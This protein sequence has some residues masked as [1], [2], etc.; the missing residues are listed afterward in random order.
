MLKSANEL[1]LSGGRAEVTLLLITGPAKATRHFVTCL[2]NRPAP[3]QDRSDNE[4]RNDDD[5]REPGRNHKE[6]DQAEG[7]QK[8]HNGREHDS[9]T[10]IVSRL[11]SS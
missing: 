5:Q 11:R 6:A 3:Q 9:H 7:R 4:Q 10:H 1:D 2:G 8:R